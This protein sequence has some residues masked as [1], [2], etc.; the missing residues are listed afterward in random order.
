MSLLRW[1]HTM[2]IDGI[3][4]FNAARF[5]PVASTATS[6]TM[7]FTK[8]VY[9]PP[10]DA[11]TSFLREV[12]TLSYTH[13][14]FESIPVIG[15]IFYTIY[16]NYVSD[17]INSFPIFSEAHSQHFNAKDVVLKSAQNYAYLS[18]KQRKNLL[19]ASLAV[20]KDGDL[21][22]L[23]PQ[24]TNERFYVLFKSLLSKQGNPIPHFP[25]S[26]L[27]DKSFFEN[28]LSTP[29]DAF[30]P[31]HL[32]NLIKAAS[33]EVRSDHTIGC[34]LFTNFRSVFTATM[35]DKLS[36][37]EFVLSLAKHGARLFELP[38]QFARDSDIA[39]ECVKRH[40]SDIKFVS[41][42]IRN[43]SDFLL[44]LLPF[45]HHSLKDIEP[46]ISDER[47]DDDEFVAAACSIHTPFIQYASHRIRNDRLV[48][49]LLL[50][51]L[52]ADANGRSEEKVFRS[53][54]GED[55]VFW[56]ERDQEELSMWTNVRTICFV[57]I[58]LL[59]LSTTLQR[60]DL[61]T[62]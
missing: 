61:H 35:A 53:T 9:N 50:P 39:F 31:K 27:N 29:D 34:H 21:L 54:L 23:V 12:A 11:S 32:E 59:A 41:P 38:S 4:F 58:S 14:F 55:V 7:L 13:I 3:T 44:K 45:V 10:Q 20:Q 47:K 60:S 15:N 28:I 16:C 51:H 1:R 19:A 62:D 52:V 43:S 57:G 49:R 37:K 25:T 17:D 8:A 48:Q 22:S 30:N 36:E 6:L 18:E 42:E 33:E 46:Y 24:P 2:N 56:K 5:L 26:T 40:P